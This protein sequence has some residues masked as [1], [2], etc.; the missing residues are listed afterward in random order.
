MKHIDLAAPFFI[1]L[2][3]IYSNMDEQYR[4]TAE[5]YGFNCR[6]CDD[7]CCRTLFFHHTHIE[8]FYLME[9]ID[10]LCQIFGNLSSKEQKLQIKKQ[11]K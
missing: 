6:G 4:Q 2:Q 10:A 7:N 3:K 11:R 5:Y 1:R 9:G 8:F